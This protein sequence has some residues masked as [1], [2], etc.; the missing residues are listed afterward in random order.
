MYGNNYQSPYTQQAQARLNSMEQQYPQYAQQNYPQYQQGYPQPYA[1]PIQQKNAL[2]S[3]AVT[4]I[5]EAKAQPIALDG[6]KQLFM[7]TSNGKIYT[8][9]FNIQTGG[10]DFDTYERVVVQPT[11]AAQETMENKQID[12]GNTALDGIRNELDT[13]RKEV[14]ILKEELNYVQPN[15]SSTDDVTAE[16]AATGDDKPSARNGKCRTKS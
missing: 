9:Q 10:A 16:P 7:D 14:S 2:S 13:L 6:T 15:E 8:K 1:Q 5:E 4:S 3:V 12:I 11:E